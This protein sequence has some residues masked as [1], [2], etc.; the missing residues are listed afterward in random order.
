MILAILIKDLIFPP[1]P[2][3][4]VLVLHNLLLYKYIDKES[5]RV[6]GRNGVY[7]KHSI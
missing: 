2:Q 6:Q 7:V 3:K 1:V 5:E 4:S